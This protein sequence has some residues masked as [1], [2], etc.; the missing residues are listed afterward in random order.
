MGKTPRRPVS[1][2][3]A[4]PDGVLFQ[5]R[6]LDEPFW[7]LVAGQLVNLTTWDVARTAFE[8]L[9]RRY[10]VPG[11]L[12]KADPAHLHAAMQPLGLWRRQSSTLVALTNAWVKSPP[13]T[14]QEVLKL[15]GCGP[16]ASQSWAIFVEGR[17]DVETRDGKLLWFLHELRRR[18]EAASERSNPRM[19]RS[20]QGRARRIR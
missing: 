6:L 16:Y 15:P 4:P 9:R 8:W 13:S 19:P 12:A 11:V 5:E 3:V 7:M 18:E 17:R 1:S 2:P 10:V 20:A 14:A